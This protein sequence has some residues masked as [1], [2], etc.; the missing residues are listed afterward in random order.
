MNRHK[1]YY[2]RNRDRRLEKSKEWRDENKEKVKE[3]NSKYREN[4]QDKIKGYLKYSDLNKVNN[5]KVRRYKHFLIFCKQ[6]K[7]KNGITLSNTKDYKNSHTKLK[8]KCNKKHVFECTPNNIR[9]GRWCP[10]C[11]CYKNEFF[12]KYIF[13]YIFKKDFKK[14]R[15]KW[16]TNNEGNRLEIDIYNKELN[17][18]IEYN[19][20]QH[21]KFVKFFHRTKENF[22]KRC[23]DDKIKYKKIKEKGL[24]LIIVPFNIKNIYEF[25]LKKLNELK[26][27]YIIPNIAPLIEDIY[28]YPE[29][30]VK[31][32]N[33]RG[34]KLLLGTY[35]TGESIIKIKCSKGHEWG[36]KTKYTLRGSWCPECA[37]VVTDETKI[38][39]SN[40]MKDLHKNGK[41]NNHEKRSETMKKQKEEIIKN[42]IE[43][44]CKNCS[45][46]KLVDEFGI[47]KAA[48]DGRQTN[49]KKC[50]LSIKKEW[51]EKNK[52]NKVEYNC[53]KCNK[54]YKLKDSLTRHI[55]EKHI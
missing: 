53:D 54:S 50:V 19:G 55:R 10:E 48:K 16:L 40:T 8:I 3:Y 46:V 42:T 43:K 26:I 34:G 27:D 33:K 36:T 37:Y 14:I 32:I 13:E 47:K 18:A 17:L 51:R 44:L 24:Q 7:D 31:I 2:L 12:T 11:S 45:K 25:V 22:T 9:N 23:L 20:A 5:K 28:D 38:K 35:A 49:C 6:V 1:R 52:D 15:P 41:K 29:E 4:N 39:I 21:Y 30:I